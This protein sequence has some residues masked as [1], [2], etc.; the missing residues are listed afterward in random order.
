VPENPQLEN[1]V[2][3]AVASTLLILSSG[4]LIR[5]HFRTWRKR[6]RDPELNQADMLHYSGQFRR[7]LQASAILGL[8]GVLM[9]AGDLL[10]PWHRAP[11]MFAIFWVAI[12]IMAGYLMLLA[13]LDV[14]ATAAH[15][16]AALARLK[17]QRR[18]LEREAAELREKPRT[19]E[20]PV[21]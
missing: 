10:V 13:V 14:F 5:S 18:Q 12:L 15:G 20:L 1:W 3:T 9:A 2:P 4:L 21:D 7:R 11:K 16:R 6:R 19:D 8:I 17:A